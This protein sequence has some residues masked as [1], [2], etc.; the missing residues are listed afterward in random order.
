MRY[1]ADSWFLIA[2]FQK[3]QKAL[4]IIENAKLK[5]DWVFIPI[6]ALAETSKRLLQLGMAKEDILRFMDKT[7]TSE[8]VT[9][10]LFTK[11]IA[12][13]AANI[14]HRYGIPLLDSFVAATAKTNNVDALISG[15]EHFLPLKKARYLS[16]LSW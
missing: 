10:I 2:L 9:L 4:S 13:E 5:K 3:D 11:D 7:E 8:R 12:W 15:D 1:C 16:L 6:T 14:A